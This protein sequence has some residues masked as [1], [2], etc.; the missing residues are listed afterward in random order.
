MAAQFPGPHRGDRA[1]ADQN[2]VPA[3][4]DRGDKAVHGVFVRGPAPGARAGAPPRPHP[5]IVLVQVLPGARSQGTCSSIDSHSWVKPGKVF[6]TVAAFATS[7]PGTAR[8]STAPA[9]TIR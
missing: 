6:A 4:V 2:S 1:V 8:P 7:I 3:P 9:M 5:D